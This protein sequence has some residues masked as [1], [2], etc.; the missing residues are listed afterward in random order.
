MMWKKLT[1]AAALA[2]L[3]AIGAQAQRSVTASGAAAILNKDTAQARDRAL[4]NALR[5]A[6]EQVIGTMVDSETLVK[7]NQLLSDKIYTQT[8]GY[9]SDYKIVS[10]KPDLD[11]NLYSL[12]VQATV[13]EGSLESDLNGFGILMRRMKMPRVA[14]AIREE[15]S[16]AASMTLLKLLKD[17]GF[18]MVDTG[19]REPWRQS[20]FWSIKENERVDLLG[21]Y[22][23]GVVI[24]GTAK[25][26]AGGSV[27]GSDMRSF[28]GTVSIKALRSDTHEVLGSASN[29]GKAVEVGENGI[30][31]AVQQA[32]TMAGNDLA[33]QITKQWARETS[34]NRIVSMEVRG[35]PT[36]ELDAMVMKLREQGRGVQDV[37][38]RESSK[39]FSRLDVSMQGDA[40]ALAQ[41]IRKLFPKLKVLSQTANGL[42]V[43]R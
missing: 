13:K 12:T 22:G 24:L 40:S 21:K 42:T 19:G 9:V 2:L 8:A 34:S 33:Q 5:T 32:A 26:S 25:G 10:E 36:A 20:D 30:T 29:S 35:V 3:A 23:A 4:E 37:M 17:K 11:S 38:V 16:E 28:Q 1:V 41:E 7:N 18:L 27:A 43:G 14:V 31:Q 15:E 39:E 6:V